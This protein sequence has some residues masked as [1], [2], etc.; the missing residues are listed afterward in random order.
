[1]FGA[2]DGDYCSCGYAGGGVT[3]G[4]KEAAVFTRRVGTEG[5]DESDFAVLNL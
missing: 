4:V 2:L 5:I 3:V 1:M